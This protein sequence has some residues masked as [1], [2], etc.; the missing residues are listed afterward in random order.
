MCNEKPM[1]N[2][3]LTLA[4]FASPALV[5]P[6]LPTL[7]A[8]CARPGVIQLAPGYAYANLYESQSTS[9]KVLAQLGEGSQVCILGESQGFFQVRFGAIVGFIVQR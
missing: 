7:A 8:P 1:I 4:L 9:S 2:R 5:S 6:T 3:L